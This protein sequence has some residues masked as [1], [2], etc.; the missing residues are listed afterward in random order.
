MEFVI[1]YDFLWDVVQ[2]RHDVVPLPFVNG[3]D[4]KCRLI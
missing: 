4:L 2:H 1:A 3:S